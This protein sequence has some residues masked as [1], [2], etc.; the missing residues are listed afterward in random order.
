[1]KED[2]GIFTKRIS[3]NLEDNEMLQ[4]SAYHLFNSEF[5]DK[6]KQDELA[7][8]EKI[9]LIEVTILH[10]KKRISFF[11]FKAKAD[12]DE[13]KKMKFILVKMWMDNWLEE[14]VYTNIPTLRNND[15]IMA[16]LLA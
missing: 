2:N 3:M 13:L 9:M 5:Y 7:L 15:P 11:S 10:L 8:F 16:F 1:M 14:N 4:W 12:L 6:Y